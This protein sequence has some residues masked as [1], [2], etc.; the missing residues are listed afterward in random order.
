MATAKC[1]D[2]TAREER[3]IYRAKRILERRINAGPVLTDPA[4]TRSWL[5]LHIGGREVEVFC[6]L[7]LDTQ[8]RVIACDDLATGTINAASVYTR[9]VVRAAIKHNAA[10]VIF[11]HNHP[12]G[13]VEASPMD[14][15]LTDRLVAAL[16]LIDVRVL[17]HFIV[18]GKHTLS[19]AERGWL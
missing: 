1:I 16:A 8:H 10:A 18:G 13:N 15:K 19:F 3:A 2:V 4:A 17:D 5:Q 11:A 7:F 9:E 6:G 14:R 12:S